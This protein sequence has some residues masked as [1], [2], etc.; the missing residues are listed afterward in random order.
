[1]LVDRARGDG[2][3]P[4]M[5]GGLRR[6]LTRRVLESALEG[7][8]IDHVGV[9]QHDP[10]GP[11]AGS[12]AMGTG[13]TRRPPMSAGA[14]PARRGWHAYTPR[15]PPRRPVCRSWATAISGNCSPV[16]EAVHHLAGGAGHHPQRP[17]PASTRGTRGRSP[18]AS[19]RVRTL[20]GVSALEYLRH[21]VGANAWLSR[22]GDGPQRAPH[23]SPRCCQH[24]VTRL[25]A[26]VTLT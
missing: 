2:L 5:E 14:G 13:S 9:A 8:I 11:A 20:F 17:T 10:K 7:Q 25:S 18:V 24:V 3:K 16:R 22:R 6:Q 19:L 21:P 4:T 26:T 12:P 1:M 23:G 15:A